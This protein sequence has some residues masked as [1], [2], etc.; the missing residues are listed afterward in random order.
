MELDISILNRFG[1]IPVE[2]SNVKVGFGT[3]PPLRSVHSHPLYGPGEVYFDLPCCICF[4]NSEQKAAHHLLQF[5]RRPLTHGDWLGVLSHA[6]RFYG[7]LLC[8]LPFIFSAVLGN[9]LFKS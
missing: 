8:R 7:S 4:T 2:E 5:R 6:Q 3:G 1:E 9:G